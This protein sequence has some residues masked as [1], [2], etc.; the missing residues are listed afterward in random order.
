MSS[1]T[2]SGRY[3]LRD[4]GEH[5]PFPL[6]ASCVIPFQQVMRKAILP[7]L[8]HCSNLDGLAFIQRVLSRGLQNQI[9]PDNPGI[10]LVLDIVSEGDDFG[11]RSRKE[12]EEE[13]EMLVN[14]G[15]LFEP[16]IRVWVKGIMAEHKPDYLRDELKRLHEKGHGHGNHVQHAQRKLESTDE[17]WKGY[18]AILKLMIRLRK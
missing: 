15:E 8:H 10:Q 7:I 18:G 12:K 17:F 2:F 16:M 9:R 3:H 4:V 1:E 14:R 11:T 5:L 13:L 6:V